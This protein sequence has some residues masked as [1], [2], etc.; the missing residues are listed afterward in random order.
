MK[1]ELNEAMNKLQQAGCLV[2]KM[3]EKEKAAFLFENAAAFFGF[4]PLPAGEKI[5]NM[6]EN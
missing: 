4:S 3:T 2:E 6:L 1:M 5:R